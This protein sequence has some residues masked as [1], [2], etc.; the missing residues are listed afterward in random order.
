MRSLDQLKK[1]LSSAREAIRWLEEELHCGNRFLKCTKDSDRLSLSP[2]TNPYPRDKNYRDFYELLEYCH[3]LNNS[4]SKSGEKK[5]VYG[6][7]MVTL[8]TH[9]IE[10]WQAAAAKSIGK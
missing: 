10:K 8:L 9:T 7:P 5:F 4:N 1:S 2:I 3:Y 6:M